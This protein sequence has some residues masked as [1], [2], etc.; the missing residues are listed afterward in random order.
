MGNVL[1]HVFGS[2]RGEELGCELSGLGHVA[3]Y[4]HLSL[5]ECHLGVKLAK[6]DLLEVGLGHGECGI[7]GCGLSLLDG[8]LS[9][10]EIDLVDVLGLAALGLGQLEGEDGVNLGDNVFAVTLVQVGVHHAENFIG[11]KC[12]SGD[13]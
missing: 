13:V 7:G 2:G 8:A 4:L 11:L 10:L 12:G 9:V 3:L 1:G 6:A 5:H